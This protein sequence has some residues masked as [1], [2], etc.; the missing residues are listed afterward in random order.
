MRRQTRVGPSRCLYDRLHGGS[1]APPPGSAAAA[2]TPY[3][4]SVELIEFGRLSEQQYAEL[5]GDENDPWDAGDSTLQWR[6]KDRHFAVRDDDGRL[7]AAAGLV[8]ADVSFGDEQS[9]PVVGIGG[10]IVAAPHRGQG[11]GARVISEAVRQAHG[12][13][14]EIAMLFCHPDRAELYRRHGFVEV[15]GRVMADQPEGVVA[16]P[17]LTMWRALKGGVTL[18]DGVVKIHGLPF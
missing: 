17:P 12:L 2:R 16:M 3:D 13:G 10:V 9:M 18:P 6:P 1:E 5:V 4:Q 7:L 11:L 14:P 8:V 15:S